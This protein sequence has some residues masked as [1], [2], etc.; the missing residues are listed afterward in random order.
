MKERV[1][2]KYANR[3]LYDPSE[4]RHLTLDEVRELVVAGE[5]V[6]VE[7][8]KTG[9][10][11]TRSILLQIIVEREEAG[12]PLLSAE[13]LEQLI[14][15]YGGAMQ[16]FLSTYLERSVGAFV[17]QQQSFQEQVL[18]MMKDTPL[19]TVSQLAEQNLATWKEL[20]QRMFGMSDTQSQNKKPGANKPK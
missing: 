17:D 11:L 14:R 15:F 12:R 4:S 2:R 20:Q 19:S 7:D 10:D 5:K 18:T 9:E 16:D 13:L 1:I 8:A 6:R 3:R